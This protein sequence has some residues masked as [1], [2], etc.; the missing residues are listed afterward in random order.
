[1]SKVKLN[2][3][4]TALG[5][6]A[7]EE[8][9]LHKELRDISRGLAS[10]LLSI[11]HDALSALR[12]Y[13]SLGNLPLFGNARAGAWYV[14]PETEPSP[15][16]CSFKSADGHYGRWSSSLRR[17]N[18]HVFAAAVEKGGVVIVDVTRSGKKWPDSL[19]KTIPIWCAV[20]N[21]VAGLIPCTC[22]NGDA[23]DEAC[24]ECVSLHLHLSVPGTEREQIASQLPNW[25]QA[26]RNAGAQLHRLVP[27]F[28]TAKERGMKPLRPLWV[29]PGRPIW[30]HGVP[31]EQLD[32]TPIVCVSA[33]TAVPLGNR[34]FVEARVQEEV[35][36][37][38]KF[39]RRSA[40]FAYV[41]GAGDDE[42][43]WCQGLT[44][45]SFWAFREELLALATGDSSSAGAADVEAKLEIMVEKILRQDLPSSVGMEVSEHGA[46]G[47][48]IW[49]SRLRL[50]HVPTTDLQKFITA[51][52]AHFDTVLI[53]GVPP[54][55]V[56]AKTAGCED[57]PSGAGQN[58]TWVPLSGKNG[59]LEY[60]YAFGRA[61]GPCLSR[62][63]ACCV[64]RRKQALVC[65]SG[66][67][68]DWSAGLAIA[69]IAWHCV[70]VSDD[71]ENSARNSD[72]DEDDVIDRVEKI[73]YVVDENRKATVGKVAKE[74]IHTT[75][76]QFTSTY[77]QFQISRATL[78]QQNR[79]FSSPAPSST[80]SEVNGR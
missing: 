60:K 24:F 57:Q 10:R 55:P 42:E 18:A 68:G 5:S 45:E 32:F 46:I 4:P 78:K 73:E 64:D 20:V 71:T 43:G 11:E 36:C 21:S 72:G 29:A 44:P 59:K 69:W 63:R 30:E 3:S 56:A 14:P 70:P 1:M 15:S 77:P 17:P 62:L 76:L 28:T 65:C 61:L 9:R 67:N 26:W 66:R 8:A 51:V 39:P 16:I 6:G 33:S 37:G 23:E 27:S 7:F 25:L 49:K 79:F 54:P 40:G 53:L 47:I 38:V 13:S 35:V 12:L 52:G 22:A 75:M 80:V 48:P 19:T 50:A 74:K 34:A 31:I 41:Q 58:I 2:E